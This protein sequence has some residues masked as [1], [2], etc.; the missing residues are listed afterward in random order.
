MA[1]AY[2]RPARAEDAAEV[3]RLQLSTWRTAYREIVPGQ[4]LAALGEELIT[5]QWR[6]AVIEPPSPRHRVLVAVE[7]TPE[8]ETVVGFAAIGPAEP[9]DLEVAAEVDPHPVIASPDATLAISALLVEPRWGRRGHGSRL[10]AAAVDLARADGFTAAVTWVLDADQASG[11][12]FASSGWAPDGTGRVLDMSGTPVHE[13][14]L[15]TS[16]VDSDSEV[17]A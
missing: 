12:F 1:E 6:A 16:L 15:V 4:V 9:D 11:K 10:L 13:S 5:A 2:V 7:A 14:R 3:A 8:L 17:E